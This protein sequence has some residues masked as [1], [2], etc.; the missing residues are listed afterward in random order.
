MI[1]D[2]KDLADRIRVIEERFSELG[3]NMQALFQTEFK[4]RFKVDIQPG[5][6]SSMITALVISTD[7]PWKQGR[8][9]YYAPLLHSPK[10]PIKGL[11][12][13]HPIAIGAFDASGMVW[14]PPAGSTI[15][16]LF[17]GGARQAPFY[18]GGIWQRDR[19]SK[20]SGTVSPGDLF[21]F[22]YN[23]EE[24]YS[25]SVGHRKGYL[26]GKNDESQ[27]FPP[28]NTENYNGFD[29]DSIED[30]ENSSDAQRLITYPNIYGWRTP[31]GHTI[32]QVD[33][34]AKCNRKWKRFEIMSSLGNWMIFKDDLLHPGGEW[35]NP[36]CTN[37]GGDKTDCEDEAKDEETKCNVFDKE[38][39][40]KGSNK[41]YKHE[42]ECRPYRGV[43]TPENTKCMLPQSGYQVLSLSGHTLV[44]DDSVE[45]PTG[46]LS[47]ERVLE[48]F[49]FGCTDLYQGKIVI[50]S[51]TGHSTTFNDRESETGVRSEDNGIHLL[52]AAGNYLGLNDHSVGEGCIAGKK[53]GFLVRTTSNNIIQASD[54]GNEQC[55]PTRRSGGSPDNQAT[56]AFI[57]ARTGYGLQF[58]MKDED[59][60]QET[61]RQFIEIIS[62]QKD[63][64]ERGPHIMRM[65]ERPNGPGQI[66]LR[67]GGDYIIYTY[68][69]LVIEVGDK[70]KNPSDKIEQVSRHNLVNT[71]K[72]YFN[73]AD[74]HLFWA[75][76]F[77][78]LAADRSCKPAEE[79]G[80]CGPCLYPVIVAKCP[81]VC[82]LTGF[83]HFTEDSMSDRV[84][85]SSTP[86]PC[87]DPC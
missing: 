5:P 53:R 13:A 17:E 23:V 74:L 50:K 79:G 28:W 59:S 6:I 35:S 82:P 22:G 24:F 86:Q 68:D 64:V 48:P 84:F 72:I 78:V 40:N 51:A 57:T 37:G 1:E 33:G 60:Q 2:V 19:K 67:A 36:K 27:V 46:T 47:W 39:L 63:N 61:R 80:E 54:E 38:G 41:F 16:L 11:P 31:E 21:N 30:F 77:I 20:A 42:A 85:A 25:V 87:G 44:F 4:K 66:F 7:D 3:Y 14:V 34:N 26:V 81:K 69:H 15:A 75:E 43:G 55:S 65:Q 71:E 9:R 56:N 49:N 29:I 8:V 12:W 52:T 32:K 45:Q 76:K 58:M 73:H 70:D 10:T 62:P 18:I 83:V